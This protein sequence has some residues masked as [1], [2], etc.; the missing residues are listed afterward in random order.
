MSVGFKYRVYFGFN[1][2]Q[3][4]VN[5]LIGINFHIGSA[6]KVI[7]AYF[8]KVRQTYI[9]KTVN[10]TARTKILVEGNIFQSGFRHN[11]HKLY[12]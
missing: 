4:L 12:V 10:Y 1:V 8:E 9:K 6:Y 7:Y 11:L 2:L 3:S 5:A